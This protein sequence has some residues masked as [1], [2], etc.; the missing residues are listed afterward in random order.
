VPLTKK[1]FDLLIYFISNRNKVLAKESIVE[2]LWGDYI[3]SADSFDFIYAHV[4]N[5]RKKLVEH[6]S[7][8]YLQTVYGVGYKFTDV[9]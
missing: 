3:D 1:E 9:D 8:D 5:L 2:H 7:N 6:G 4:S